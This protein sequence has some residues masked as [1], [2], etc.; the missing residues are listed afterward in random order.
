MTYIKDEWFQF[1]KPRYFIDTETLSWNHLSKPKKD[2]PGDP[3]YGVKNY[4]NLRQ[5]DA[6]CTE[7]NVISV[8]DA[9]LNKMT[10]YSTHVHPLSYDQSAYYDIKAIVESVVR[11]DAAWVAHNIAFDAAAL[12][13]YFDV[14]EEAL[15]TNGHC[16]QELS[17]IRNV[18][19]RSVKLGD[20]A[21]ALGVEGKFSIGSILTSNLCKWYDS[22]LKARNAARRIQKFVANASL[23]IEEQNINGSLYY[24]VVE[25]SGLFDAYCEQDVRA[26]FNI[27]EKLKYTKDDRDTQVACYHNFILGRVCRWMNFHG[28][29]I[30]KHLLGVL[31]KEYARYLAEQEKLLVAKIGLKP[32]QSMRIKQYIDPILQT[33]GLENRGARANEL[34]GYLNVIPKDSKHRELFELLSTCKETGGAKLAAIRNTMWEDKIYNF[35]KPRGAKETG[36]NS[37]EIT[38]VQ[39]FSRP[40]HLV[41][42]D[43]FP[44]VIKNLEETGVLPD[45]VRV[46]HLM[47]PLLL[48]D[49]G[50]QFF[51]TDLSQIEPR[52][53]LY[54]TEQ[55][56][57]LNEMVK[58]DLYLKFAQQIYP[59]QILNK[60]SPERNV[61]KVAFMSLL[62]GKGV[63][64]L[65]LRLQ[66]DGADVNF[67]TATRIHEV[68]HHN[69][70]P[71]KIRYKKLQNLLEADLIHG[72][73]Y[74]KLRSGRHLVYRNLRAGVGKKGFNCIFSGSRELYGSLLFAA[75]NQGESGDFMH[76]TINHSI[77]K[78]RW[79]IHI[80]VHDQKLSSVGPHISEEQCNEEWRIAMNTTVKQCYPGFLPDSDG[81]LKP[82]FYK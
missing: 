21:D 8:L 13:Y 47:R 15:L 10:T 68:F 14:D 11:G 58:G 69:F 52:M 30:D 28:T 54:L 29:R 34:E 24:R 80:T 77:M 67:E 35:M 70:P 45:G 74:Y 48:P 38:Q 9:E 6:P 73:H 1:I 43:Q 12:S 27:W 25:T 22:Q 32:A 5:K 55:Y 46:K 2:D 65:M 61:A 71:F 44:Q 16:T 20:V 66:Q 3:R 64:N 42:I 36:R 19:P 50:C 23:M 18:V 17:A 60:Q 41:K 75:E 76:M 79:P 53:A 78:T 4:F 82:F 7:V 51:D 39:N 62:Y 37:S 49:E 56:D 31:E 40:S 26:C 72:I 59:G 63:P 57:A 81:G 33:F